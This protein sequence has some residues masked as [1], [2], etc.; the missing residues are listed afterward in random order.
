MILCT[1]CHAD[2]GQ[3]AAGM[4]GGSGAVEGGRQAERQRAAAGGRGAAGGCGW[5]GVGVRDR[6][7]RAGGKEDRCV[8]PQRMRNQSWAEAPGK[9][10]RMI[11]TIKPDKHG[12]VFNQQAAHLR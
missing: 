11:L 1:H 12:V 3:G 9:I 2:F 6:G 8:A 4:E 5:G 10:A 7:K